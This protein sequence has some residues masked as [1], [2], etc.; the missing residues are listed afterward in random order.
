MTESLPEEIQQQLHRE[1]GKELQR[2]V[3]TEV[4]AELIPFHALPVYK[5]STDLYKYK[6]NFI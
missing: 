6:I 5:A 3:S 2:N 4:S 1:I